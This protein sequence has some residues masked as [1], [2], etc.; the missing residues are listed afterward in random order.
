MKAM[1]FAGRKHDDG[2]RASSTPLPHGNCSWVW[3]ARNLHAGVRL[4]SASRAASKARPVLAIALH[5]LPYLLLL[6][7][8]EERVC[9]H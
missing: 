2:N 7:L 9:G 8:H 6:R 1:E 4:L 5:C 3:A